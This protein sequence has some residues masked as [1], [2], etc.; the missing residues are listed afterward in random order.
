MR[1]QA[2]KFNMV[3]INTVN[4][5]KV[6]ANMAIAASLPFAAQLMVPELLRKRLAVGQE[7]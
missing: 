5:H 2:D 1:T 7:A 6:R 3:R 4:Q